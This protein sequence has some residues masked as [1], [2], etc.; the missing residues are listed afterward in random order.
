MISLFKWRDETFSLFRL[1][2]SSFRQSAFSLLLLSL[3]A[4]LFEV[5]TIGSMFP[6]IL[7][8]TGTGQMEDLSSRHPWVSGLGL[9][10]IATNPVLILFLFAIIV[11][12]GA[13]TRMAL[14]WQTHLFA[15][16]TGTEI[17]TRVLE[18]LLHRPFSY[19]FTNSSG[20]TISLVTHK[21]TIVVNQ[22]L[23]AMIN[24][25]SACLIACCVMALLFY[26]NLKASLILL[27]VLSATYLIL[28]MLS[29]RAL[30]QLG[31]TNTF[32]QAQS[33]A[34]VQESI[35]HI[36]ETVLAGMQEYFLQR[37]KLHTQQHRQAQS[38]STALIVSKR[39]LVEMI[40]FLMMTGF[41]Y[42]FLQSDFSRQ[43]ILAILGVYALA[44]QRLLP[45][46]HQI[47]YSWANLTNSRSTMQDQLPYLLRH[48]IKTETISPLAF[49]HCLSFHGIT[50][51]YPGM[52][53]PLFENLSLEI[54]KG[55]RIGLIGPSGAGKTTLADLICGL[56]TPQSGCIK[57]D[58]KPLDQT[59]LSAW[60]RNIAYVPQHVYLSD[61]TIAENIAFDA[62]QAKLDMARVIAVATATG[63][64]SWI[65]SLPKKYETHCGENGVL[66][67]GGQRQRIGIARALYAEK[68]VLVLDEPTSALDLY[69]ET[70]VLEAILN[71]DKQMTIIVIT[72]RY[73]LIEKLDCIYSVQN[74][75]VKLSASWTVQT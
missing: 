7:S 45:V 10:D 18:N 56:L 75:T 50:F 14:I 8:L 21:I 19:Y 30:Y 69:A 55:Q 68:P 72:H 6:I 53:H 48:P 24:L 58:G 16:L 60:Q 17:A 70:E 52:D 62:A 5:L 64:D 9:L 39:H 38:E 51:R 49:T 23:I 44:A 35:G 61:Q 42:V 47:Y 36:R 4:S 20:Q 34:A 26:V 1:L 28:G 74:K 46:L 32:H 15:Q 54:F 3:L 71:L 40:V 65:Q 27:G 66:L 57:I 2:P 59:S 12:A 33:I 11:I 25:F 67:S 13:A 29:K 41:I 43:E 22:V 31:K 37:F 63:I 73:S